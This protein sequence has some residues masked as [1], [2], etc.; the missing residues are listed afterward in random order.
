MEQNKNNT[1][2]LKR[3]PDLKKKHSNIYAYVRPFSL[4]YFYIISAK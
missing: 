1:F 3:T 2:S 4:F